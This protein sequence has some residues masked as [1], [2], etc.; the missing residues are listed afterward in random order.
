MSFI[1]K[2]V[3]GGHCSSARKICG[4]S[5]SSGYPFRNRDISFRV[6]GLVEK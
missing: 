3:A 1:Q 4:A 6:F 5:A 2:S